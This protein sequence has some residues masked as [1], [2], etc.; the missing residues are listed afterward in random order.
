[1]FGKRTGTENFWMMAEGR[2]SVGRI[3]V[4]TAEDKGGKK[5]KWF[6]E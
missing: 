1:M 2:K 5:K 6:P 4:F 3:W